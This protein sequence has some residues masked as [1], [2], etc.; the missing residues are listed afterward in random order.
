MAT[1]GNMNEVPEGFRLVNFGP[2]FSLALGPI[3]L[4]QED[5]RLAFRVLPSHC[6]PVDGCHGGVIATFADMQIVA[7]FPGAEV[8]EPHRP[9]ISL[10]VDYIAP[11][12][13]G[14]WVEAEVTLLKRTR[15]LVFC[16]ALITVNGNVA[17]RTNA[18]YSNR[19]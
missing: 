6:N 2:G 9:T 1:D 17:A 13:L 11:I 15:T 4:R 16:S 14:A 12:A 18:I 8:G 19:D 7:V 3:F 10:T 5:R